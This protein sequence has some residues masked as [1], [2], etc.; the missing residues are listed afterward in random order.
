[1]EVSALMLSSDGK[2]GWGRLVQGT[3][4]ADLLLRS[5]EE[6]PSAW[7][8]PKKESTRGMVVSVLVRARPRTT[9]IGRPLRVCSLFFGD[10]QPRRGCHPG[11]ELNPRP[12]PLSRTRPRLGIVG[13]SPRDQSHAAPAAWGI[14]CQCARWRQANEYPSVA[15][16]NLT[17]ADTIVTER[18]QSRKS[19]S[20]RR[21]ATEQLRPSPVR[22]AL[23]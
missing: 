3:R 12:I 17:A 5:G 20:L 21:A 8:T 11:L 14:L 4:R 10:H 22:G 18:R 6:R 23:F 16:N 7:F 19:R 1:L 9:T 2:G 13:G 15:K